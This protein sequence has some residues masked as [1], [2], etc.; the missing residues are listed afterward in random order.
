MW[1]NIKIF[2]SVKT[3]FNYDYL[4]TRPS[5]MNSIS[6]EFLSL[7]REKKYKEILEKYNKLGYMS[8]HNPFLYFYHQAA[9]SHIKDKNSLI[10]NLYYN[11]PKRS[12]LW[13]AILISIIVGTL[14]IV[15]SVNF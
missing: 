1:K 3:Y 11:Q 10:N 13:N 4:S 12:I 8:R 5:K 6:E 15:F 2:K 7:L 9:D 14:I